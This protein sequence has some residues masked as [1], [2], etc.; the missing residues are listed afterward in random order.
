MGWFGS[1]TLAW[2]YAM[3]FGICLSV[4]LMAGFAK[5]LYD[6]NK[7]KK[8]TKDAELESGPKEDQMELNAREKDEGDLFG[9]RAIEAGYFAGIPQSRPSS[10]TGSIAGSPI[11]S[12]NTLA[13]NSFSP[14]INMQSPSGSVMSLPLAHTSAHN[15]AGPMSIVLPDSSSPPRR[16]GSPTA[17]LRPSEAELS[18]RINHNAAVNMTLMVPPSPV[19]ASGPRSPTFSG[20]DSEESD[21]HH[22]HRSVS[23]QSP[24]FPEMGRSK[25][26]HYAPAPPQIPVPDGLRLSVRSVTAPENP[27]FDTKSQTASIENSREPSPEPSAPAAVAPTMPSR[28]QHDDPRSLFP[29]S[30]DSRPSSTGKGLL[31]AGSEQPRKLI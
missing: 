31:Q 15:S 12:T 29:A 2:K 11:M 21:D 20:S 23:P 18:G 4:T 27:A 16:M 19:L 8:H 3:V 28:Y 14:K 30:S 25:P 24:T 10:T 17:K 1:M 9:V 22:S 26:A 13:S 6:R 5:V 7:L